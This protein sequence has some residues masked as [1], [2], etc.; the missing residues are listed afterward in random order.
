[1]KFECCGLSNI[2]QQKVIVMHVM[3]CNIIG[4]CGVLILISGGSYVRAKFIKNIDQLLST[5]LATRPHCP[6]IKT[7]KMSA[8]QFLLSE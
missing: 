6:H 1:V 7:I 3:L 4:G 8:V 5:P 2:S